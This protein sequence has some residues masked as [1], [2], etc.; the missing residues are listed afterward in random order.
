MK[1]ILLITALLLCALT[2]KADRFRWGDSN[3]SNKVKYNNGWPYMSVGGANS[4]AYLYLG[5]AKVTEE[6][7]GGQTVRKM[8]L[9][10]IT[11]VCDAVA[12]GS[13]S[14]YASFGNY[15]TTDAALTS[16]LIK[17][18]GGQVYSLIVVCYGTK[19]SG[20]IE[21]L[22]ASK[23][24]E[25]GYYYSVA[26]KTF[27]SGT[28]TDST[29]AYATLITDKQFEGNVKTYC[30]PVYFV[31]NSEPTGAGGYVCGYKD[32]TTGYI[33][34]STIGNQEYVKNDN[35]MFYVYLGTA[36]IRDDGVIDFSR[37]TYI[38]NALPT[39]NGY[40]KFGNY[41]TSLTKD[42]VW[43]DDRI[44]P[45]GGQD[46][47]ILLVS[48]ANGQKTPPVP[49]SQLYDY[50]T[51]MYVAVYTGKSEKKLTTDLWQYAEITVNKPI[52]VVD[53]NNGTL[54][55]ASPLAPIVFYDHMEYPPESKYAT[56]NIPKTYLLN[57]LGT[58]KTDAVLM[59]E[60]VQKWPNANSP[61][62]P[63]ESYVFGVDPVNPDPAK[64]PTVLPGLAASGNTLQLNVGNVTVNPDANA[65]V[66]YG[67]ISSSSP[68][69]TNPTTEVE[70]QES[71]ALEGG[72]PASGVKYYRANL[73]IQGK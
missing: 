3:T 50:Q 55:T 36:A 56:I 22:P 30:D 48:K 69:F 53:Y 6:T 7:E 33:P 23:A 49:P 21:S 17:A 58:N 54:G 27:T 38:T 60:S 2:T 31:K 14:R 5:E 29:G 43:Q 4:R 12:P 71:P 47:T 73:T 34:T 20:Y 40:G 1:N 66:K 25:P 16:D 52:V 64:Q 19:K 70:P 68:D 39:L 9:D 11:Y 72:L 61:Y 45:N 67:L 62:T 13:G 18:E 10:D 65:D 63:M 57:T 46:Y 41:D 8:A 15:K 35:S 59:A 37:L 26:I 42:Q 32:G 44:D 51:N 28:A 24:L